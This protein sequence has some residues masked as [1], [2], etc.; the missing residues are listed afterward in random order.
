MYSFNKSR[1]NALDVSSCARS[2][3]GPTTFI[4]IS[5]KASATPAAKGFSGPIIAR[6]EDVSLAYSTTA[7]G[8][9]ILPRAS[10][11]HK[12][13]IPGFIFDAKQWIALSF[14]ELSI[15]LAIAC[16]LAPEPISRT[17]ILTEIFRWFSVLPYSPLF[18]HLYSR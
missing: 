9:L 14:W 18:F 2:F 4:P 6:V 7:F 17:F 3:L 13:A 10:L 8:S 11:E 15:A 5:H 16:S 1:V 12:S